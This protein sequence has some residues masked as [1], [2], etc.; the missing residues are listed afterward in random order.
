MR[1]GNH[2]GLPSGD[3]ETHKEN[4][5]V[6]LLAMILFELPWESPWWRLVPLVRSE[7]RISPPLPQLKYQLLSTHCHSIQN[8]SF[9]FSLSFSN[10]QSLFVKVFFIGERA[11]DPLYNEAVI[12]PARQGWGLIPR[13]SDDTGPTH[14]GRK[15]WSVLPC[16]MKCGKLKISQYQ[17]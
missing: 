16:P 7:N 14:T 11:L 4:S 5:E 10:C 15:V 17:Y 9:T 12:P 2:V 13:I 8:S 3:L 1:G 6:E